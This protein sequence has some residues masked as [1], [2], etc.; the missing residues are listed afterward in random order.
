[1]KGPDLLGSYNLKNNDVVY[2]KQV[3][4]KK[5]RTKKPSQTFI[6][7]YF[8]YRKYIFFIFIYPLPH[9][10]YN[11]LHRKPA[12]R[13][14]LSGSGTTD[15]QTAALNA[16]AVLNPDIVQTVLDFLENNG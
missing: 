8:I 11:V 14:K 6:Y 12:D 2:I 3:K 7:K 16:S 15:S 5:D 9:N 10:I 1:M 13:A 4:E